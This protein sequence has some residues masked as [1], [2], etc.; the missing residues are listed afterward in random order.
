MVL[1]LLPVVFFIHD[2]EE[3]MTMERWLRKHKDLPWIQTK[4]PVRI[5]WDIHITLQFAYAVLLL[6][7]VLACMTWLAVSRLEAQGGSL[8]FLFA[9]FTAVFLLDGIKHAAASL[10]VRSYTPGVI[11]AVLL[12]I[13]YGVYALYR[14]IREGIVNPADVLL[15]TAIALPVTLLLVWSGLTLGERLAPIRR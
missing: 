10:A 11:T 2:G 14:L 1:W 3:V 7:F 12:E 6:G 13:P 15:G 5:R 8:A 9:G 4:S